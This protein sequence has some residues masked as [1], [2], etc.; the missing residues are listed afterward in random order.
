M[1]V[2]P[3]MAIDLPLKIL[4]AEDESGRVWISYNS[5][6]YLRQRHGIPA[7]LLPVIAAVANLAEQAAK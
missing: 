5:P 7:D 6:E 3:S 2:A 4:V 1:L